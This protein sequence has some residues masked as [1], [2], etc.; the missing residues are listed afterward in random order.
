MAGS[1][2]TAAVVYVKGAEM[3]SSSDKNQPSVFVL[4]LNWN[5][6][7]DTVKCIESLK[8]IAYPN[9]EIL[10]LDNASTNDSVARIREAHPDVTLIETGAN[11]GFAGGNNVG[12]R[13]ALDRGADYI[14][15]LNNDTVVDCNALTAL[16]ENAEADSKVGVIGSVIYDMHVPTRI[17]AWGG[18]RVDLWLGISRHFDGPISNEKIDYITGASFLV[19]SEVFRQIGLLDDCFF[20]YWEDADFC[21][22]ARRA[23][24]KI[25]VASTSKIFHK[26]SASVGQRSSRLDIYFNASA[27][28]FFRRHAPVP[29]VPLV[30]GVGGRLLKRILVGDWKRVRAVLYGLRAGYMDSKNSQEGSS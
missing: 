11:L 27:V 5:G 12:I 20:M 19:R 15:L 22:R 26:E 16:V 9:Y 24:W 17:Q 10:V 25:S 14:W 6:W 29:I 13:Y 18:G 4:V 2:K 21:L 28:T 23:G 8:S 30:V 7:R 1:Q 3:S